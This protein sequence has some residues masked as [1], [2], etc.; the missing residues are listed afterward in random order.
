MLQAPK[1]QSS[2]II[3]KFKKMTLEATLTTINDLK[4]FIENLNNP[5]IRFGVFGH[6]YGTEFLLCG[7]R[8]GSWHEEETKELSVR[9]PATGYIPGS[10]LR[11]YGQGGDENVLLSQYIPGA[12]RVGKG[13]MN[14][15]II[16]NDIREWMFLDI[17]TWHFS[18]KQNEV[19][20]KLSD[21]I[22]LKDRAMKLY[23]P[24]YWARDAGIVDAGYTYFFEN[25]ENKAHYHPF[26]SH[27]YEW[28][29]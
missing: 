5:K 13:V 23:H 20:A 16:N 15:I 29:R 25:P 7:I 21:C 4:A 28:G 18:D 14:Q 26:I 11:E 17:S 27:K 1:N 3:F 9:F 12:I 24:A 22:D 6:R 8:Y 2:I 19:Y 10:G